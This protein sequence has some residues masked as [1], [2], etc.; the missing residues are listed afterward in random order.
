MGMENPEQRIVITQGL[1]R[2]MRDFIRSEF[3]PETVQF[4]GLTMSLDKVCERNELKARR[5]YPLNYEATKQGPQTLEE[6][7]QQRTGQSFTQEAFKE[8][9]M[10]Q[11]NVDKLYLK[12][13]LDN[14]EIGASGVNIDVEI[15]ANAMPLLRQALDV[16]QP[17]TEVSAIDVA[18]KNWQK[19]QVNLQRKAEL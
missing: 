1:H 16:P 19:M 5:Y 13:A 7:F 14:D 10:Q 15:E 4:V 8:D 17:S 2:R 12:F 3:K 9:F 18:E 6:A 11:M